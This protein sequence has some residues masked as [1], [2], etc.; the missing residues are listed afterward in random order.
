MS[1]R[2]DQKMSS[3]LIFENYQLL[4]V[5]ESENPFGQI[6]D[7]MIV[8]E[9]GKI[10]WV[11]R[12]VD[13]PADRFSEHEPRLN[14]GGRFLTPGLIDCHTHLVY[15][16]SRFDEWQQRLNGKSYEE[17]AR[18]GGGIR[19]TVNATRSA[20]IDE[21]VDAAVARAGVMLKCGVTTLEIKSGYGL[22]LETEIKMLEAAQQ[23]SRQIPQDVS[24]TFLGAHTIPPEF[25]QKSDAYIDLVVNEMLPAVA[26]M[27]EAVDVFCENIAFNVAQTQRVFEAAQQN[28]LALKIHAEQLS[29]LGG[30]KL[31]AE[32]GAWSADHLEYVDE[33]AIEAMAEN[34]T[35]AV[36]LPG[37]FYF[38]N[39]TQK[40]PIDLFRKHDLPMALATDH[41]PGS[42]PVFSLPL[43]M[44]FGCTLF[45]MTPQESLQAVTNNAAQALRRENQIGSLA[46][47][48]QADFAVWDIQ[49]PVELAYAIGHQSCHSVYKHG[50]LVHSSS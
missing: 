49:S 45:G 27:V 43:M 46:V 15:G 14:G 32:M 12:R 4:C 18:A 17:I 35:I 44:N 21:L 40:P 34:Q 39:E 1:D 41:N 47:G 9:N 26:S 30:A 37:A 25:D 20:N 6:D 19:S 31:A 13:F 36:L 24:L 42:S 11:G 28:G 2:M 5:D 7:G 33:S 16:G 8:V 29:N 22:D 10:S 3:C 38:I 23:T 48:K 50:Q